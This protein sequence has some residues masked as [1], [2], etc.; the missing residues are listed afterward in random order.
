MFYVPFLAVTLNSI[1]EF[2]QTAFLSG[3]I[4][5]QELHD[6]F[7]ELYD[8]CINRILYHANKFEVF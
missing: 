6:L 5:F 2:L 7:Q 8:L 1:A 4:Q 3:F